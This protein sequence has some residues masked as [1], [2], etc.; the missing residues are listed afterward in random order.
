M[1]E[2][3]VHRTTAA[4]LRR[5]ALGKG[6]VGFVAAS[7]GS[8]AGQ[9]HFTK[10]G[11]RDGSW[12]NDVPRET[13]RVEDQLIKKLHTGLPEVRRRA[14]QERFRSM[15]NRLAQVALDSYRR[16]GYVAWPASIEAELKILGW[17]TGDPKLEAY[18]GEQK[19][20]K[21]VEE[22]TR[23]YIERGSNKQKV[24]DQRKTTLDWHGHYAT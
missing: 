9:L 12:N 17:T 6:R 7:D 15:F 1:I 4:D 13:R 8:T 3:D 10:A 14:H 19:V 20:F 18:G 2:I 22:L 5:L 11:E 16:V 23:L 21:Q 24:Q